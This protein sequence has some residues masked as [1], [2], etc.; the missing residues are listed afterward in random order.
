MQSHDA[1]MGSFSDPAK[2]R[3]GVKS[4]RSLSGGCVTDSGP[5]SCRPRPAD[6]LRFQVGGTPELQATEMLSN[7]D[8]LQLPPTPTRAV[9]Q[10]NG[11]VKHD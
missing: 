3:V 5:I 7:P 11:R 6:P 9:L 2:I 1:K 10:L 4:S 8:W